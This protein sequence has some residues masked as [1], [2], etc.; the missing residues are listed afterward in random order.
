M[1]NCME[2]EMQKNKKL[3]VIMIICIILMCIGYSAKQMPNDTFYTVRIGKYIAENGFQNMYNDPFSWHELP[4]TFPHW[5]YDLGI[6]HIFKAF[7]WTR[8][9]YI[10][11]FVCKHFGNF[12]L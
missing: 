6:F 8:Y 11:Y 3:T 1:I 4:Y 5:L 10:N 12:N 7:G 2:E 9:I